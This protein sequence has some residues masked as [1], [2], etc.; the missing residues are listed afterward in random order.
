MLSLESVVVFLRS[1]YGL[2]TGKKMPNKTKTIFLSS[3]QFIFFIF[4]STLMSP[5]SEQSETHD[6]FGFCIPFMF[7][8]FPLLVGMDFDG[9]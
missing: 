9:L 7:C 5:G 8:F 6:V 2:V 3:D 4:K 1:L